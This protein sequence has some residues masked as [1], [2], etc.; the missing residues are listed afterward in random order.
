[1]ATVQSSYVEQIGNDVH[2]IIISSSPCIIDSYEVTGSDI[3]FGK[4]VQR[5]TND[6]EC[7]LGVTG[8]ATSFAATNFAGVALLDRA[9]TKE[10]DGEY[11]SGEIAAVI[12]QGEIRLQV[13]HAVSAG[14]H[15][16]CV[17]ATGVLGSTTADAD[18]ATIPGAIWMTSAAADGYA[19]LRLVNRLV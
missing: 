5:G 13:P 19:T 15:V 7:T 4:A 1:M 3:G 10:N 6:G 14:D 17:E 2:G 8:H 9:R 12:T 16:T 18:N 11:E